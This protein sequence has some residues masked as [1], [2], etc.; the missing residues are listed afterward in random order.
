MTQA[1]PKKIQPLNRHL[2]IVPDFGRKKENKP[3]VLLPD[4]YKPPKERYIVADVLAVAKDCSEHIRSL[5]YR[6]RKFP[7]IVIDR[8]MVEE[9]KIF[10]KSY[11][12]ILENH[13]VGVVRPFNED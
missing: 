4:G 9:I 6:E 1:L 10:D 5:A 7:T 12:F 11:Y 8:S 3:E 2:S 13:V